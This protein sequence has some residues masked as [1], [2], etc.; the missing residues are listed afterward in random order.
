MPS[1]SLL[2]QPSERLESLNI[3]GSKL[4]L[5]QRCFFFVVVVFSCFLDFDTHD[6]LWGFLCR[7]S[8]SIL[9]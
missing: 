4:N 1:Y 2:T 8:L 7:L 6:V 5:Y 3:L 9:S